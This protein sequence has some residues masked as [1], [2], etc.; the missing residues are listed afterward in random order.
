MYIFITDL[1]VRIIMTKKDFFRLIIKIFGLY[2]VISTM[3]SIL[4]LIIESSTTQFDFNVQFDYAGLILLMVNIACII[5]F[6]VFL[7]YKPD[8]IVKW[9]KLDRGFDDDRIDFQNFNTAKILKL[10][11]IVIGGLLLIYNIPIFLSNAW[12]AFKSSVGSNF[13]NENANHF[14]SSKDYLYWGISFIK[15]VIGYL[16]VTNYAFVSKLLKEKNGE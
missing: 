1:K 15:I 7:I 11:L 14:G 9:F 5:L 6:F 4:P 12:F 8:I 3:F 13:N 2:F 16:L 10:A